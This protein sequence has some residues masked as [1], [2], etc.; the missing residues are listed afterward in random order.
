MVDEFQDTNPLQL[1]ILGFLDRG[2]VFTVGDELQSIY[3]F[4]HADVGVFRAR[5]AALAAQAATATLATSFRAR[6]EI[7]ETID[8]AFGDAQGASWV[9][10]RPGR[11][12]PPDDEPRVELLL[13]DAAAW[14]GAG[15]PELGEGLPA[16]P[17]ARHAEAR[18][19]AQ[20]IADIVRSGE[21]QA[22]DVAVLLR[23]ATDIGLY[24]RAIELEGLATLASGG[25]GWWGRRQVQDLC[26]YLGALANPRDEQ[27]LLGLLASPLV[28][29][30]SDALA[31]LGMAARARRG[32][33]WDAVGDPAVRLPPADAERLQAFRGWFP[34]ERERAGRLALD[35]LL[36]R[37][38]RRT[39]YDLHVLALPGGARRLANVH[40][41]MRL[42]AGFEARRGR[43]VRGF[44]DHATAELEADAREPDAP[45]DLS[46]LQAVRLMTIHAAK[47]LEFP[48]V[49][50]ADLGRR[51]STQHPDLL[52]DGDRVGLR[53]VG[54]DNTKD[55]ALDWDELAAARREAE[56]AEER[57][58]M[59]V[60]V[61]RAEERLILSGAVEL[62]KGWP[63]VSAG[64]PPL[65]W[66]GPALLPD[67]AALS[68]AAPQLVREWEAGGHPGRIR[69]ALNAPATLGRVLRLG[70]GAPGEQ[71]SL[72]LGDAA[73]GPVERPPAPASPVPAASP[74]AAASPA[75]A[76]SPPADAPPAATIPAPRPPAPATISYSSLG[77]Y[78]A[79]PYRFHLER[80]L[81]LP[82]QDPP[83]HLRDA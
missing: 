64:A 28:G 59:H 53:L 40:K 70:P 49:V 12:E 9:A 43:D 82:E 36:A 2:N 37:V 52:V 15:L 77:R 74:P 38:V 20:R 80:H 31:L 22:G 7:L 57:R 23:A 16:A 48:V 6:P 55:K 19:V 71:L 62:E 58:V 73:E 50:V 75:I 4:R 65:A 3:G 24:E 72:A 18:L 54:L 60:A 27:A 47:G 17:A 1:E 29:A 34:A 63:A 35:E 21:A 61:T 78:A 56:E 8:A 44:I 25:R 13:T 5:R 81:G 32:A 51:G 67:P 79:C 69:A 83:E 10:L 26:C 42:A 46:G 45:V 66:M 41:L 76:A 68:P 39:S 30:S 11:D 33:L 14:E